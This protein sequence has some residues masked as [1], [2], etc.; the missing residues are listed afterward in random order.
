MKQTEPNEVIEKD[1]QKQME[2]IIC[3]IKCPKDFECYRSGFKILCRAKDIGLDSFIACLVA[4]PQDCKFSIN[5]GE[6]FFCHCPLRICISKNL[7][8]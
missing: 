8:K 5:F 1:I 3:K 2:N 7:R 6:A 4:V